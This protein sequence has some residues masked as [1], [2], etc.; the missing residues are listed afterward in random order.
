MDPRSIAPIA[1]LMGVG[2]I[3]DRSD[4]Q[5]ERYRTARPVPMWQLL[6]NTPGLATPIAFGRP[7]PNVAGPKQP[8]VDEIALGTDPNLPNPPPVASFAVSDP[9]SIVR[10]HPASGALLL[11]GDA[12]GLVNAAA[13]GLLDGPQADFFSAS[14]AA[15][16]SGFDTIYGD[17]ADLVVTDTNRKRAERWGTIREQTG[18]TER[19]DEVAP[20][21]P[22]D[23]RLE[24]FPDES[25]PDQTVTEQLGGAIVTATD[26]GNPVTYTP[27]DRPANAMDGDPD[28]SWRVGALADPTGERLIIDLRHPVTTDHLQLLQPINLVRNRWLTQVTLHFDDQKPVTVALDNRS[29]VQPGQ[30][31]RFSKRTFHHLEIEV[32]QTNIAKRPEYDGVSGVGFAEVRI[33]GVAPVDELVRPPTDLLAWAGAS[34]LDHR[35]IELF[36]RL[37]SD[38]AEPVRLDEEPQMKRILQLPVGRSFSVT[39]SA[40]LSD[41]VPDSLIDQLLGIPDAS[42]GGI[43]ADSEHHLPGSI[44]MRAEAAL[45]GDP[46]TFWSGP[47]DEPVGVWLRYDFGHPIRVDHLDLQLVADGRHSVPTQLTIEPD[48]DASRAV[49]V[50]IPPVADRHTPN[51]TVSVPVTLPTSVTGRVLRITVTGARAVREKDWYSNSY[52]KAPVAIAELGIPGERMA[53][54]PTAFDSGCRTDLLTIDGRPVPLR[55]TGTA[56]DAVAR[57]LLTVSSCGTPVTLAAGD[58]VLATGIGRHLGID[59]DQLALASD[60]GGAALP[61]RAL[62]TDRAASATSGP[63]VVTRHQGRTGYDLE[64]PTADAPFWLAADQ[65][66]ST[67]WHASVNGKPLPAPQVIDGYGNG[68]LIDPAVYGHGPLRIHVSWQP[69]GTVWIA[70]WVSVIAVIVAIALLIF[71]RGR[72]RQRVLVPSWSHPTAPTFERPFVDVRPRIGWR[73]TIVA[74]TAM[75]VFLVLALP[76]HGLTIPAMVAVVTGLLVVCYRYRRGRGLLGLV[77]AASLGV[78]ALYTVQS[79]FRHHNPPDFKWPVQF[80]KINALGLLTLVLLLAEAGRELMIRRRTDTGG[81]PDE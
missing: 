75:A 63:K 43:T 22:S 2:D 77:A 3:V 17:G 42:E 60:K 73:A 72:R 36:T 66:W 56:T 11:A 74:A 24:V 9:M 51:A 32:R 68:W 46:T 19:A 53:S 62:L 8:M 23:Q 14:Y 13:V 44:E 16:R 18:Y 81:P 80:D 29:R 27:D 39:G 45:D 34:S 78:A 7:V 33:P 28:S 5:Y 58:H 57:K 20:Y 41:Y 30:I 76:W 1:R 12:D 25:S 79:Q 35:L 6:T 26:Y 10:T 21:D 38:P 4:L 50:N 40:A 49:K 59:I 55:V 48:G 15:D 71:S 47:F 37:R 65:S 61:L 69:Q 31:V 54:A 64:V 70:I 52:A 67:G